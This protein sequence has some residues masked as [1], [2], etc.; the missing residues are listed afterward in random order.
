MLVVNLSIDRSSARA[1]PCFDDSIFAAACCAEGS[2]HPCFDAVYT[3]A[4]CCGIG[5]GLNDIPDVPPLSPLAKA[6]ARSF[7][8]HS[9]A[10]RLWQG[11]NLRRDVLY[12]HIFRGLSG[13]TSSSG[14]SS[15]NSSFKQ[16]IEVGVQQ[17]IFARRLLERMS[18]LA[19]KP[20]AYWMVDRWK[21]RHEAV[22]MQDALEAVK[23][24]WGVPVALQLSSEVA[25][26]LFRDGSLDFVYVDAS[27][28]PV[29]IGRG[30][31]ATTIAARLQTSRP[32]GPKFDREGFW[33]GTTTEASRRSTCA[34]PTA[35]QF[36]E[37]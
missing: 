13:Q 36:L 9:D 28:A 16:L 11:P 27:R 37:R 2:I 1:D 31:E 30:A 34:V 24:F 10:Y 18:D 15:S 3:R 12:A 25:A 14:G 23:Q 26:K 32:G 22:Y 21:E 17:G 6:L 33:R 19:I 7:A 29:R 4:R 5:D 35:P 8:S 20:Q